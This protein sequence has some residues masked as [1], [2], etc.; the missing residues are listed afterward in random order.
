MRRERET[1]KL[2]FI[3]IRYHETNYF[4]EVEAVIIEKAR[5][6]EREIQAL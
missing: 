1:I 3:L 4:Q 6:C 2:E 5:V